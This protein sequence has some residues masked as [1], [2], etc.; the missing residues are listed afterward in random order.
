MKN[1][2]LII[3]GFILIPLLSFCQTTDKI[4]NEAY[5]L[6]RMVN[7]FHVEPRE[8]NDKFSVDLFNNM[9][10]N[11]D[12]DKIFFTKSDINMLSKYRTTLDDQ[13]KH[14]KTD[15][16][17]L[18]I[19]IY[20]RRLQQTD[21]A[22]SVISKKPF[23]FY[24][25]E[26]LTMAEDTTFPSSSVAAQEKLYKKLRSLTL[27]ELTDDLPANFKSFRPEKQRNYIDSALVKL[28]A[29]PQHH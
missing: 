5:I 19:K 20:K 7:K 22:I 25:S 14:R 9:L 13:I 23:D 29:K 15:Y 27:D 4:A 21:S 17:D 26:K 16:L 3:T 12:D 18:F 1:I 10:I 11:T 6:I 2:V 24:T 28:Q 8:V